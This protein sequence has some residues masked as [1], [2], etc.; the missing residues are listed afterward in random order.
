MSFWIARSHL[1][2]VS[3]VVS[4]AAC[5]SDD[6]AAGPDAD[7]GALD[8]NFAA[9]TYYAGPASAA[10]GA[11]ANEADCA[12]CH[13]HDGEPGF[14]GNSF[15]DIAY[16]SEF[17]G[18]DAPSLLAAANA[19]VTGWMGG[20]ALAEDDPA[21][22]SLEAYLQSLSSPAVTAPNALAPEILAD[23]EAYEQAHMGGDAVA[24]ESLYGLYC[25]SCHNDAVVVGRAPAWPVASLKALSIGRIAQKVRTS[26]PPPS[27]TAEETD[28]TP[29]PMP[30]FEPS[31]LSASD[32]KDIIAYLKSS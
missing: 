8:D 25:G 29:G 11:D 5:G 23:Q 26:G 24:G 30:F 1:L 32:L 13:S 20:T 31:D 28:T 17:K 7:A 10:L 22:A 19:C 4:A 6:A 12:L 2:S 18:G 3:L 27:G 21:W 9:D 15:V 16:R 14:A